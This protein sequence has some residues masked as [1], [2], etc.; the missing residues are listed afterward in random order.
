MEISLGRSGLVEVLLEEAEKIF[1]QQ[2]AIFGPTG[3]GKS[4]LILWLMIQIWMWGKSVILLDPDKKTKE[5]AEEYMA[6]NWEEFPP[7]FR[8]Q[9]H[10]IEFTVNQ[11]V[12]L[13]LADIPG[14]GKERDFL[15]YERIKA[16]LT[17]FG[18]AIG[19]KN[20][21]EQQRRL[22][23]SSGLVDLCISRRV[24]GTTIGLHRIL[25][26]LDSLGTPKFLDFLNSVSADMTIDVVRDLLRLHKLPRSQRELETES[27]RNI[28][29]NALRS[30]Q[31][32]QSISNKHTSLNIENILHRGGS[33]LINIDQGDPDLTARPRFTSNGLDYASCMESPE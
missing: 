19:I 8:D 12:G 2:T 3:C 26:V 31:I 13:D 27:T 6:A 29:A 17:C 15:K 7:L 30:P 21:N 20:F 24:D 32:Y 25:E 14:E 11:C 23:V 10:F 22:R 5:Q 1:P 28:F 18:R 16:I 33:M 9:V 4:T